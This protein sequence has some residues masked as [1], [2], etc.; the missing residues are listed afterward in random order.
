MEIV[1]AFF[2]GVISLILLRWFRRPIK[3][4]AYVADYNL[5]SMYSA[6]MARATKKS[7]KIYEDL[8]KE[9]PQ[10]KTS[11][12]VFDLLTKRNRG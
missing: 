1:I 12:E 11:H 2:L 10:F 4:S 7:N 3:R 8:I 6:S 9:Y 5:S